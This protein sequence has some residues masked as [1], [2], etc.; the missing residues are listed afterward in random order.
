MRYTEYLCGVAMIKGR[1]LLSKAIVKLA[2][3]EDTEEAGKL[4][5]LPCA[6]NDRYIRQFPRKAD[7]L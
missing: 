1:E 4:L 7:I 6:V 5:E 2:S 3:H